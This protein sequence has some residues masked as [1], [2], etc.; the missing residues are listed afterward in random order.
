M[1]PCLVTPVLLVTVSAA[2]LLATPARAQSLR[3][4]QVPLSGASLQGFF[5]FSNEFISASTDQLNIQ[6][7]RPTSLGNSAMTL[8]FSGPVPSVVH[9][10]GVYSATDSG[11]PVR[12]P[13]L[14]SGTPQGWFALASFRSAPDRITVT[15]FDADGT[16]VGP[17]TT[18]LGLN[19]LDFGYYIRNQDGSIGYSQDSRQPGTNDARV[20]TYAGTGPNAG[21]WWLCFEDDLDVANGGDGRD[22]DDA[23]MFVES[24]NQTPVRK[25]SWGNLKSRFR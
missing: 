9:E 16:P 15:L 10:L 7:W 4:P 12:Y 17:S 5:S 13:I 21:C 22:F 20:L 24:I 8:A 3:V 6:R 1:K 2:M 11:V 25:T 14:P 18:S 23:V 19:I